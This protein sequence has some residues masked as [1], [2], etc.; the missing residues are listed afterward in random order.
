M[1][2]KMYVKTPIEV[3]WSFTKRC[4][5]NC[6]FC[7]I[8]AKKEYRLS[9]K[10]CE[11][12]LDEIIKGKV[13]KVILTGGE[14]LYEPSVF[15]IIKKLRYNGIAV[16]LTTNGTLINKKILKKLADCGLREIQI[17]INGS[18]AEINDYLMGKSFTKIIN[19]IILS[20]EKDFNVHTKT[21]ITSFN[22]LDIPSL[23]EVLKSLGIK[24]IDLDEVVPMGRALLNYAS[25]KPSLNDLLKLD[26]IV[27]EINEKENKL[28]I[29]FSS[30]TLTMANDGCAA[31]CSIGD[32][33][34]YCCTITADGNLYPCTLSTLW[35]KENNIIDKGI[36]KAWKDI[37][38]FKKYINEEKLEGDCSKCDTKKDCKGGCRP[39]AYAFSGNEWSEF[40]LCPRIG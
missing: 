2:K 37:S 3:T 33:N 36:I 19:A 13:L 6:S 35:N 9:K 7:L 16:E 5:L 40:P 32:E 38:Y 27:D 23:I 17:S 39:L 24:K 34:S 18:K 31:E 29:E 22:I 1:N 28:E 15:Q 12:V 26:S 11:K 8:D 21:T 4:N 14:P 10:L 20:L 30:F 25:L